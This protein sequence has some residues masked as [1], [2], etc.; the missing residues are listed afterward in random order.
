M[1][2]NRSATFFEF[3]C[4]IATDSDEIELGNEQPLYSFAAIRVAF[5]ADAKTLSG[6]FDEDGPVC[7]YSWRLLGATNVPA[8]WNMT[9]ASVFWISVDGKSSHATVAS[10]NNVFMDNF[11]ASSGVLSGLGI[12]L[13][14]GSIV[15]AWPTNNPTCHL[16]VTPSLTPPV[17]WQSVTNAR[18]IVGTN[19][20]V[21]N[22][23][24][25][26]EGFYRLSR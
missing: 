14:G 25:S 7:G 5:D 8:A 21:T 24:S 11:S 4:A 3:R 10:T 9:D 6:Y 2:F 17:C 19:F 22:T 16:E 23:V 1:Q 18:G 20:T 12:S 26:D 13:L 15:L